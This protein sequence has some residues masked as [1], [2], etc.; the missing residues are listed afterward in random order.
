MET[1]G[2]VVR[3][4]NLCNEFYHIEIHSPEV[5]S[6][7]EPGQFVM[8]G[9]NRI[10]GVYDPLF[11]RPISIYRINRDS[12]T[13]ELLYKV[14]GTGT[15]L[16]SQHR[17]GDRLSLLGPL[18]KGISF[19]DHVQKIAVVT[20]GI[21]VAPAM[22]IIDEAVKK[23]LSVYAF[24]SSRSESGLLCRS[25]IETKA[26]ETYITTD[27]ESVNCCGNVTMFLEELLKKVSID[28]VYTCGSKR[29]AR[30]IIELKKQ[31]GFA[32]YILLEERMA[33]GYGACKGCV[34]EI[35]SNGDLSSHVEYQR[36]CTDGPVFEIDKV[37]I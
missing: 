33:C 5:A 12:N 25:E 31:Y 35:S 34:C 11:K 4:E 37:V 27:D 8:V 30:H 6:I 36:V 3:N 18:G 9:V 20:R 26:I 29:L 19:P 28:V 24:L 10:G 17:T 23:K 1:N 15:K 14:V 21:G 32:G 2:V 16:L 13:F 7:V 22:A